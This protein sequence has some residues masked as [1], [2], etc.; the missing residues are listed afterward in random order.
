MRQ[1]H[2][3]DLT[4]GDPREG[5]R[6]PVCAHL[7][8]HARELGDEHLEDS[9][10][11]MVTENWGLG[12]ESEGKRIWVPRQVTEGSGE[13]HRQPW[14]CPVWLVPTWHGSGSMRYVTLCVAVQQGRKAE[15]DG[16]RGRPEGEV[17]AAIP[18]ALPPPGKTHVGG[19]KG[20]WNPTGRCGAT[21]PGPAWVTRGVVLQRHRG[22]SP[23]RP[24]SHCRVG[25]WRKG[26]LEEQFSGPSVACCL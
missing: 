25:R 2:C 18:A 9:R 16:P 6:P 26:V 1:P 10:G 13:R 19:R 12:E 5:P 22:S 20:P 17:P 24:H 23:C 14:H 15:G 8:R 7:A 21:P 3:A 11:L 4:A